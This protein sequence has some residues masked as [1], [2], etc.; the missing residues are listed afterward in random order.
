M[1]C[2]LLFIQNILQK[3]N[4]DKSKSQTKFTCFIFF[5]LFYTVQ[6][7]TKSLEKPFKSKKNMLQGF[8]HLSLLIKECL[9][10]KN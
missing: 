7:R 5:Q 9:Q 6:W 2:E 10:E 3:K 4:L 8:I 1:D